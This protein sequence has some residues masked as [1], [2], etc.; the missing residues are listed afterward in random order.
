MPLIY[1]YTQFDDSLLRDLN[2]EKLMKLW[3]R[4][5]LQTNGDIEEAQRWLEYLWEQYDFFGGEYTPEDFMNFL[6]EQG[7]IREMYGQ[8]MEV[9]GK[10]EGRIRSDALNEVFSALARGAVGEHRIPD[11]GKGVERQPETRPYTF[12]D[13][14]QDIHLPETIQN[15]LRHSGLENLHVTEEDLAVHETEHQTS[16][17]TVLMIDISHSMILYGEDRITP[18]KQVA[19]ALTELI[20]TRYP[21]DSLDVVLFGDDAIQVS[22]ADLPYIGVGPY[23]TNTKAGLEMAQALLMRRR[24][25]NKQ[26][27]MITDGKPSAIMEGGRLY[28]N[29]FGLDPLIVNQTLNEA[30]ACRRKGIVISTFMIT[31]DPYLVRFVDDFTKANKGRAYYATPDNVGR[32]LFADYVRNKRRRFGGR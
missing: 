3:N 27:F 28:K 9:T 26:I 17:A 32:F 23:H 22:L 8:P 21:K 2:M 13:S 24:H 20:T 5:L 29:S 15:A 4:L 10:G 18:A 12:G 11:T 30:R 19:L 16:C 6:K 25:V 1:R 31:D 14:V 7:Y